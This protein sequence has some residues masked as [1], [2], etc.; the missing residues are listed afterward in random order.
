MKNENGITTHI[1]SADPAAQCQVLCKDG[2]LMS[3]S[4]AHTLVFLPRSMNAM[5]VIQAIGTLSALT[6]QFI[7][8]LMDSCD[9]CDGCPDECP[10]VG[11]EEPDVTLS[12][13]A[14]EQLGIPPGHKFHTE[15]HEG[16]AEFTDAGYR[17]D[18]SDVPDEL[19]EELASA[20]VC[21]GHL[22]ELLMG[23]EVI[24]HG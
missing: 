9:E 14:R 22:D 5:E 3:F 16:R 10:F 13:A 8:A 7:T 6:E 1:Y 23:G 24:W 19:R 18:I 12:A 11:Q 20:G 2:D 17:H 15:F 21:L 4:Q